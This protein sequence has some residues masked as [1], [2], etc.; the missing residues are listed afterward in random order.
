MVLTL[1]GDGEHL[2]SVGVRVQQGVPDHLA[3]VAAHV[4]RHHL[5]QAALVLKSSRHCII[6][7]E[8][9]SKPS[10]DF[11][12]AGWKLINASEPGK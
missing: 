2:R 3:E 9:G 6:A 8:P 10:V 12:V 11:A 7:G 4:A 1:G 5:Q